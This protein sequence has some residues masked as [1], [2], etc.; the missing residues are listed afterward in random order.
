MI[1][2][3]AAPTLSSLVTR[4]P[5]FSFK[6]E[7][8]EMN[9]YIDSLTLGELRELLD[10]VGKKSGSEL[11]YE[12]GD[13]VFI[14][15]VTHYHTGKIN[16]I[17]GK[18][19]VLKDASWIPDTGRFMQCVETGNLSE[20]EPV[21]CEVTVNTDTIVDSYPWRHPLPRDQK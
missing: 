6:L 10:L 2:P 7:E 11:P 5:L 16:R 13:R 21:T 4:C 20:C 8:N 9:S 14:R 18:F 1:S 3:G 19:L 15:T 17:V 12:V